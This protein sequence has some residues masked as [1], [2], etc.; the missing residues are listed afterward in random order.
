MKSIQYFGKYKLFE[1]LMSTYWKY[2]QLKKIGGFQLYKALK[3]SYSTL[4][5]PLLQNYICKFIK[6]ILK[7]IKQIYK[8]VFI[9]LFYIKYK[10]RIK[11]FSS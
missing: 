1:M 9:N 5:Y 3:K 6:Y 2:F 11:K 8:L 7:F 4:M 10:I